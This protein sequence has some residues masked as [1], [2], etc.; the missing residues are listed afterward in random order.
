MKSEKLCVSYSISYCTLKTASYCQ[1]RKLDRGA[2]VAACPRYG[3]SQTLDPE[4][5]RT[6][7][8]A[9]NSVTVL[10][11]ESLRKAATQAGARTPGEVAAT[12]TF[13]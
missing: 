8:V 13:Q 11:L 6:R 5:V 2:P 7:R 10:H 1:N 12:S 3:R 4:P 9:P